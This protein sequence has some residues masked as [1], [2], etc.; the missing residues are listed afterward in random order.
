MHRG[1]SADPRYTGAWH[2]HG[3]MH[4]PH[5]GAAQGFCHSCCHPVSHCCCHRE[6]RKESKELLVQPTIT[7]DDLV[8][9]PSLVQVMKNFDAVRV[10]SDRESVA[11]EAAEAAADADGVQKMKVEGLAQR[12]N[13]PFLEIGAAARA[14]IALGMEQTFIGGGCCV[15]LSVEYAPSSPT[16]PSVLG[17]LLVDA[18]G[19]NLIWAKREEAGSGYK[20]R[21]GIMTTKP[22]A[23]LTVIVA[24]MTARVRWCEVFS[25]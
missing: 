21:E 15:H 25:C 19:T 24:N 3:A 6:C 9:K 4:H 14:G 5:H 13:S 11:K 2:G 18:E 1:Y 22:G 17:I 7:R 12:V 23:T 16:S 10:V 20:V 8:N